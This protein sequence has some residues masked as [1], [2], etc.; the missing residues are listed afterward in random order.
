MLNRKE[1]CICIK[2][3]MS[4]IIRFFFSLQ[5]NIKLYHWQTTSFARHSAADKLVDSIIEKGDKFMEVYI[6]KYGRPKIVKQD[7]KLI[8][9]NSSD[10]EIV[11]VVRDAIRFVKVD[12]PKML[13]KEDSDLFNI[14]DELLADLNQTLYLFTLE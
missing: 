7:E 11:K 3:K 13:N 12:M 8:L 5:C 6:G 14:L 10:T 4:R 1:N 9:E 2:I